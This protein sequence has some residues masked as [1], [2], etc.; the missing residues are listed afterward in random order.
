MLYI[1]WVVHRD[2][3]IAKCIFDHG[4]SVHMH[5]STLAHYFN[6]ASLMIVSRCYRR[7]RAFTYS[8]EKKYSDA[9]AD[10]DKA[11]DLDPDSNN[12][13]RHRAS[14]YFNAGDYKRALP[15]FDEAIRRDPQNSNYYMTRGYCLQVLGRND[16]AN[17]DFKRA[18]ELGRK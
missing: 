4:S 1:C 18:E 8:Q 7:D 15:D 2:W 10:L 5:F 14:C 12:F 16:E 13:H 6:F 3:E 11:L 17:R 9:I